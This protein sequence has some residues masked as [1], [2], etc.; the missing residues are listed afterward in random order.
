M[1]GNEN[2]PAEFVLTI[3]MRS[4]IPGLGKR[5]LTRAPATFAPLASFTT[6]FTPPAVCAI[7]F[8][9]AT[10]ASN[11]RLNAAVNTSVPL[12]TGRCEV[13]GFSN[14]FRRCSRVE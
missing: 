8:N 9:P 4:D 13:K 14:A 12:E 1:F 6:P 7:S 3:S 5:K 11:A 2:S 10:G